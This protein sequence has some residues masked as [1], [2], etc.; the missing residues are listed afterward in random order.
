MSA[1][2]DNDDE[3]EYSLPR[4]QPQAGPSRRQ[5]LRD[6]QRE[7]SIVSSSDT[8]GQGSRSFLSRLESTLSPNPGYSDLHSENGFGM[9]ASSH[10]DIDLSLGDD[11]EDVLDDVK[12][13]GRA[14]VKER[15]TVDI[16]PWEGE[17]MD[18]IFNKLEQQVCCFFLD[19]TP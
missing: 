2:F 19:T 17:L 8:G 4:R 13:L 7:H 3:E 11:D 15:G 6:Q 5:N 18:D 14:W 10:M 1:F 9:S 12:K 16:M